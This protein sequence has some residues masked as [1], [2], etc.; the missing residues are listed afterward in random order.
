MVEGI[1]VIVDLGH[2]DCQMIK[3][4]VQSLGVEAVVCQHDV[5]KEE[6]DKLG[7]IKGFILDGGPAKSI[8]GFRVDASEAIYQRE[9]PMYSV[10]HACWAGVDLFT[11]PKDQAERRERIQKFLQERCKILL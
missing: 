1:I 9:L 4:D 7:D 10:D 2:D 11:W 5:T 6:L 8:N 3:E